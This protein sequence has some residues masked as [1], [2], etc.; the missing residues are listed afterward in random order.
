MSKRGR[1]TKKIELTD[2][3]DKITE[4]EKSL[5]TSNH[6]S[7]S[8]P[9]PLLTSPTLPKKSKTP[10]VKLPKNKVNNNTILFPI[11]ITGISY[12][13]IFNLHFNEVSTNL[14]I[15]KNT[16]S[17]E[18]GGVQTPFSNYSNNSNEEVNSSTT[19]IDNTL[20]N[21]DNNF[22][23]FLDS[24]KN[25]IKIWPVMMG[26]YNL[27]YNYNNNLNSNNN[28]T[29]T[30]SILPL[31][32]DKPCRNCHNSYETHPIGCPIKYHPH[33]LDEKDPKRIKIESFLKENN[34]YSEDGS[35]DYFETE[36]LFC[37]IPCVKSYI[38]S[39]LSKN[40][41]SIRYS[42]SLSYLTVMYKKIH[43]ISRNIILKENNISNNIPIKS[44]HPIEIL[45]EY[46]GSYTIDE[47]RKTT[48]LLRFDET[49]NIKRPIMFA[50]FPCVE[51]V[52][53][54]G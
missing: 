46:G 38:I 41:L 17:K 2:N 26:I 54:K 27:S 18:V 32:T 13:T 11:K 22:I 8:L 53:I 7:M 16:L 36:G 25:K 29:E 31:I 10:S 40:P 23:T 15:P 9:T 28:F 44:A 1:P 45:K 37:S 47:Y 19:V 6:K 43:N 14:S 12:E 20:E 33:I 39:C 52:R 4:N 34:F 48:E 51:E 42:N 50:C 24:K 5:K 30:N 3:S 49:V 21:T 35:T